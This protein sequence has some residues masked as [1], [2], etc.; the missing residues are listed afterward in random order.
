MAVNA[1]PKPYPS[2]RFRTAKINPD[3]FFT[4]SSLERKPGCSGKG[5]AVGFDEKICVIC[6]R[7]E[8]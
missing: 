1:Q 6:S 8:A 3:L 4:C 5:Y 7:E 2:L